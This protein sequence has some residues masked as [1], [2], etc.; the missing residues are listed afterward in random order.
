MPFEI[1]W[2]KILFPECVLEAKLLSKPSAQTSQ[3]LFFHPNPNLHLMKC[4][5]LFWGSTCLFPLTEEKKY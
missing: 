4:S 2:R 1:P 5:S 3:G